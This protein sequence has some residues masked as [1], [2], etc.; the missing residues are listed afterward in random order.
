[1]SELNNI[2]KYT[3][4]ELTCRAIIRDSVSRFCSYLTNDGVKLRISVNRLQGLFM[5]QPAQNDDSWNIHLDSLSVFSFL[6]SGTFSYQFYDIVTLWT[7]LSRPTWRE[8][9]TWYHW[10]KY[11][12]SVLDTKYLPITNFVYVGL[13]HRIFNLFFVIVI[14]F[15]DDTCHANWESFMC[16]ETSRRLHTVCSVTSYLSHLFWKLELSLFEKKMGD[17]SSK[18]FL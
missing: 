2:Y 1:M 14:Q 6:I 12:S 10:T 16:R 7:V 18:Y 8:I 17:R 11:I 3:A 13:R 15:N 5:P 4:S 9:L